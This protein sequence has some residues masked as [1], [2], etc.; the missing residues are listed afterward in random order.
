[1][2]AFLP[3]LYPNELFY[4]LIARYHVRTGRR[5]AGYDIDSFYSDRYNVPPD[6]EFLGKLQDDILPFL[7]NHLS[8]ADPAEAA[9]YAKSENRL[10]YLVTHHTL[11]PYYSRFMPLDRR[12]E[13]YD[14]LCSMDTYRMYRRLPIPQRH[15]ER[16]AR[17]CPLC[18]AEARERYGEAYWSTLHNLFGVNVCP[19][20]G[21]RLSEAHELRITPRMKAGLLSAE[22]II[23]YGEE[24]VTCDNKTEIRLA[25]YIAEVFQS[26]LSLDNDTPIGAFLQSRLEPPYITPRGQRRNMDRLQSDFLHMY[27]GIDLDGFGSIIHLTKIFE[28][29]RIIPNEIC[30]LAMLI[31]I[32]ANELSAPALPE[33]SRTE[34]VDRAIWELREKGWTYKR[35]SEELGLPI[36]TCKDVGGNRH[37]RRR[38]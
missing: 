8:F 14:A 15:K 11:F 32:T 29:K 7:L 1:M 6:F 17:Y 16:Y 5:D 19:I 33:I 13:A 23:P 30:A 28:E 2:I 35:I 37:K 18:S 26:P 21:C 38:E 22:D 24:P 10:W 4:S 9:A 25:Q 3:S 27:D 34:S 12:R 20:H 36:Y 31:G